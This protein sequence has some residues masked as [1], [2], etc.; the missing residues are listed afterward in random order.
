MPVE[1]GPPRVE[2][3]AGETA[4][5]ISGSAADLYLAMWG[6]RPA[7]SLAIEGDRAAGTAFLTGA[8]VP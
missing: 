7:E 1:D 4:A 6:R 8:L 2:R 3:G 5:A